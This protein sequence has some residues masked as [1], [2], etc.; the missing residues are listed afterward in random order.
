VA[1]GE[2]AKKG[3]AL[4]AGGADAAA[5]RLLFQI[6]RRAVPEASEEYVNLKNT[7]DAV[8]GTADYAA[9][10][11]GGNTQTVQLVDLDGDGVQ[12]AITFFRD[13]SAE[14]PLK[15]Y[16]FKQKEQDHYEAQA[17]IEGDGTA[18][19][20]ILYRN[21]GGTDD[22]ELV[23]SWRMSS[24]VHTLVAYRLDGSEVAELMRTGYSD[25]VAADMDKDDQ[26]ELLLLQIDSA[27]N[28]SSVEYYD[29]KDGAMALFSSAPLSADISDVRSYRAGYLK[30]YI[31]AL[32]VTSE[33]SDGDVATDIFS[34][35][36]EKIYDL[37]TD[38]DTGYS[39]ETYRFY[40][41]IGP[42]DINDDGVLELPQ[43]QAI[44][45]YN[46]TSSADDFW[47]ITWR[48]YDKHGV[49][50]PISTSY[51]DFNTY[52]R[53]YLI[54]PDEW[55]GKFTISRGEA[56]STTG[57]RS[58]IFSY[59]NGNP[60]VKPQPFLTIYKLTGSNRVTRSK[61][62]SRFILRT[63]SDAIYAAEF[64][65]CDWDCGLD[66]EGVRS[67]FSLIQTDWATGY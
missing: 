3:P 27:G 38:K 24:T 4:P 8:K 18:I 26:A 44:W 32:F 16:I 21:L 61:L 54:L 22:K 65:P 40:T 67:R 9:P 57:E 56:I 14:K 25:Y 49:V 39:V 60:G 45:A 31:P 48:Q 33:L 11:S 1:C 34:V 43:P 7:I 6:H 12:E 46:K 35:E 2:K 28:D 17:V 55:Q 13:S 52:D 58:V 50:W 53:W 29:Y 41:S 51:H 10:T 47:I 59:W 36:E 5:H 64:S 62:G 66:E 19:E 23:V 15:I 63:E 30:N 37:T 20:S 42:T